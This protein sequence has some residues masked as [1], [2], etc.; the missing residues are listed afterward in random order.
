LSKVAASAEGRLPPLKSG[1][2]ER[3]AKSVEVRIRTSFATPGMRRRGRCDEAGTGSNRPSRTVN[4]SLR[5]P[6]LE[7]APGG[8][9]RRNPAPELVTKKPAREFGHEQA[10]AKR[11]F[12]LRAMR[13]ARR[14]ADERKLPQPLS[15]LSL[16]EA[17]GRGAGRPAQHLPRVNVSR[18]PGLQA[19]EG[20][21][22]GAPV[23]EVR[24]R[25]SEHGGLGHGAARRPGRLGP[26]AG[27]GLHLSAHPQTVAH[28]QNAHGRGL[29]PACEP[30]PL[31]AL[32]PSAKID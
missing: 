22:A 13:R 31:R 24:H 2:D 28:Y 16:L 6:S 30:R 5:R 7:P 11:G 27:G 8:E 10:T 19:Q 3:S 17:R 21:S 9:K 23:P 14:A 26:A 32:P 4:E 15:F 25:Q 18:L 12:C 1:C 29:H 20:L